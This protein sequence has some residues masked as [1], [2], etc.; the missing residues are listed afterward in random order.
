MNYQDT[1]KLAHDHKCRPCNG[2]G[3]QNDCEPGDTSYNEWT[4]PECDGN[5]WKDGKEPF[6]MHF[7]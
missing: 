2:S 1:K 7:K 4:C 5:G 6:I 3:K